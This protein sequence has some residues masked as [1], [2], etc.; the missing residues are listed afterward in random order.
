MN[1]LDPSALNGCKL[2]WAAKT[3]LL[4]GYSLIEQCVHNIDTH[5]SMYLKDHLLVFLLEGNLRVVYGKQSFLVNKNEMILLKKATLVQYEWSGSHE[6][7]NL[8]DCLMFSLKSELIRSFLTSTELRISR[9]NSVHQVLTSVQPMDEC[10]LAF[11]QSLKPYFKNVAKVVPSQ[12]RHKMME[13]LYDT[14]VCSQAMFQQI[15]HL[16]QQVPTDL[17]EVV[18]QHY[19]TQ[20]R[21]QDLAYLSGRS[22]S[23]FKRDFQQVYNLPP[24]TWIREKRLNKAKEML[25]TT[26]MTVSEICYSLGFENVSHFS[27]IFKQYHGKIPT[28]LRQAV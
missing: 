5:G 27:R 7:S 26:G 8:F 10:L 25:E 20:V 3:L 2:D 21:I 19:A 1:I 28:S 13:L 9:Q 17:R 6:N 24:A 12:L 16:Q 22:L 23:S 18:E 15:L 14:A 11:A 4:D